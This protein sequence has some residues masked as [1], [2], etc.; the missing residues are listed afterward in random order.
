MYTTTLAS[1]ASA[2]AA[3]PLALAA[4]SAATCADDPLVNTPMG[5]IHHSMCHQVPADHHLRVRAG[6]VDI[7]DA[8]GTVRSSIAKRSG[9]N[10]PPLG[11]GWICDTAW[12]NGSTY[13]I[14]QFQSTWVVPAAPLSWD[15]QIVYLFE[16]L[17]NAQHI[18]QPVLQYG[19][20]EDGGGA[21]WSV[22]SWY[23]ADDGA[24]YFTGAI[25]VG[26][27][28]GLQGEISWLARNGDSFNYLCQF[29]NVGGTGLQ[30][31]GIGELRTAYETLEAYGMV[32][33]TDYPNAGGTEFF[34]IL[35][36]RAN[37]YPNMAWTPQDLVTDIGQHAVVLSNS[38]TAGAV[39]L[40]Y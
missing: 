20:S 7:V 14:R 30:V 12:Y 16:G 37:G 4:T 23:V 38:P 19:A 3:L 27:G 33:A 5:P 29:S 18:L 24:A 32:R 13:A 9:G 2:L 40:A 21:F 26:V 10:P 1:R 22:A 34:N 11:S 6:A 35:I 25:P 17:T 31:D 15:G 28:A 8:G 36:R 39:L